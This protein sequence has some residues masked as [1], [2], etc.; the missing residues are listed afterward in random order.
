M[1]TTS[2]SLSLPSPPPQPFLH[3]FDGLVMRHVEFWYGCPPGRASCVNVYQQREQEQQ[4]NSQEAAEE[5]EQR[6]HQVVA[7]DDDDELSISTSEL[8]VAAT[9]LGTSDLSET[10]YFVGYDPNEKIIPMF[11]Y[12]FCNYVV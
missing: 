5:E 3:H 11:N 7:D 9:V 4:R 2:Q 8:A 1:T 6:T 12:T 10:V